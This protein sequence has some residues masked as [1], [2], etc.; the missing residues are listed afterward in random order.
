MKDRVRPARLEMPV[1][2]RSQMP[3]VAAGAVLLAAQQLYFL[4]HRSHQ[5]TNANPPFTTS[6]AVS[7]SPPNSPHRALTNTENDTTGAP[8]TARLPPNNTPC[9]TNA[10]FPAAGPSSQLLHTYRVRRPPWTH[11]NT[12]QQNSPPP[13]LPS[14]SLQ[15]PQRFQKT[16]QQ[17]TPARPLPSPFLRTCR[18]RRVSSTER[19]N[20]RLLMVECCTTPSLSAQGKEQGEGGRGGG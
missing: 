18:V 9:S 6:G 17:S 1:V 10:P 16:Q 19:P 4:Q 3:V 7:A 11:K 15:A 8:H 5:I 12:Q 13:P 14:L 2:A 20:A